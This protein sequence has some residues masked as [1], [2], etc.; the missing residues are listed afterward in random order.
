MSELFIAILF[1][2]RNVKLSEA[3]SAGLNIFDYDS[4]SEGAKAY[5]RLAKEV[6]KRNGN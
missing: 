6:V 3:P 5:G 4:H 2:P 1:I